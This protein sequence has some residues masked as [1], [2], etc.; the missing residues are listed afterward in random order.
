MTR[1]SLFFLAGLAIAQTAQQPKK[2][3]RDLRYESGDS[4]K[5]VVNAPTVAVPRS[6]ALVV[7]VAAYR[8][9]P[10]KAQLKFSERDA[11][12]VYSILISPEGGNFRA[13]NVHKLTGQKA[14]LAN[15]RHELEEGLPTV[16]TD[17]DRVLIYFAG[18]GFAYEGNVYLALHDFDPKNITSSGYAVDTPG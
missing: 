1:W 5:P 6:Y 18:H 12:S 14:T 2:Q 4:D 10:D 7:G 8:N 15:F 16:A 9:L 3:Q 11:E 17:D 13:E